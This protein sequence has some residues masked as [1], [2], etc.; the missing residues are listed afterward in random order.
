MTKEISNT[1]TEEQRASIDKALAKTEIS[2]E[3]GGATDVQSAPQ[4][5]DPT[6]MDKSREIGQDLQR[7]GVT[8]DKE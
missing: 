3:I 5:N 8:M 7:Q 6:P 1:M 4:A 2:Q